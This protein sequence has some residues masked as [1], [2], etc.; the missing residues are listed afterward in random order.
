[1]HVILTIC[2]QQH[3][4]SSGHP[5]C[6][7]QKKLKADV[8]TPVQIFNDQQQRRWLLLEKLL[9]G[10]EQATFLTL[11]VERCGERG[12]WQQCGKRSGQR[13]VPHVGEVLKHV[14]QWA[15]G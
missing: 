8:I 1:M 13:L 5:T 15:V 2:E 14:I 12:N 10:L 4:R 6:E 9:A 11:W 3:R 7:R